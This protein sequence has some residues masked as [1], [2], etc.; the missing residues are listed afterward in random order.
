MINLA[1]P[2]LWPKIHERKMIDHLILHGP[3]KVQYT[4]YPQDE[5]S[6]FSDSH[7][8]RKLANN[9][10]IPRLW[11]MYSET[12]DLVFCFC[13]ICFDR[14]SRASLANDGFNDWA[15]LSLALKSHESGSSHM[16]FYQQWIEA[17][18][19]LKGGNTTDKLEQLFIQKES[20][21]WKNVSTRLMTITL[22]LA[23]KD[24]AFRG[25]SDKLYTHNNGKHLGL[26]QLLAKFY[27]VMQE[28]ICRILKGELAHHYCEKKNL[29]RT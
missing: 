24:M 22:Y 8:F 27:P 4:H 17:E 6:H 25:S 11:S 18:S 23:E 16:K 10:F 13:F 14:V 19:R 7:C 21:R 15:H 28:H 26:F 3:K 12:E 2:A 20:E 1:D 5:N 9:E 29:K